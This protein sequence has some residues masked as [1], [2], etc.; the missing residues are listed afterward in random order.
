MLPHQFHLSVYTINLARSVAGKN[1][2]P[3]RFN[4]LQKARIA[5]HHSF[6]AHLKAASDFIA[7]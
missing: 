6:T 5:C 3:K 4:Q 1:L 2:N 7:K